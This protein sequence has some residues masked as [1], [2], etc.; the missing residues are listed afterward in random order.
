VWIGSV[1]FDDV[2][3]L[4]PKCGVGLGGSTSFEGLR[5]QVLNLL[6]KKMPNRT[7]YILLVSVMNGQVGGGSW[8]VCLYA[9]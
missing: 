7:N 4:L 9:A 3:E 5:T 1:T 6:P 2:E 8:R